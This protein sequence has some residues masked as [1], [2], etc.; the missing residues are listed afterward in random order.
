MAADFLGQN[1]KMFPRCPYIQSLHLP[2]QAGCCPVFLTGWEGS[3]EVTVTSP[4]LGQHHAQDKAQ[5]AITAAVMS[6]SLFTS[7]ILYFPLPKS[8]AMKLTQL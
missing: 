5:F 2:F 8:C 7:L 4:L 6:N 3:L 1:V